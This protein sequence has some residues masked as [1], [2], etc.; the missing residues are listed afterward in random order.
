M[1]LKTVR[2]VVK[3]TNCKDRMA[4]RC[5]LWWQWCWCGWRQWNWGCLWGCWRSIVRDLEKHII[6]QSVNTGHDV[7]NI[8][9]DLQVIT[10]ALIVII[11]HW[12]AGWTVLIFFVAFT[13]RQRGHGR[14][15]QLRWGRVGGILPCSKFPQSCNLSHLTLKRKIFLSWSMFPGPFSQ[16]IW[17]AQYGG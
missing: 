15:Q 5:L 11:D 3:T 2:M 6:A 16:D 9:F 14:L 12:Y 4:G 17:G 10:I 8:Q 13:D 7:S 1:T